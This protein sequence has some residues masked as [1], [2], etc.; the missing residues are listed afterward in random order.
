LRKWRTPY[1]TLFRSKD[2]K[3]YRVIYGDLSVKEVAPEDL[4]K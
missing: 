2:A 1:L 4:P 3:T